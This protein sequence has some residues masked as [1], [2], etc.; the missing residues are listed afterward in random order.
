VGGHPFA[1]AV[2]M[3]LGALVP[4][5]AEPL[6][7]AAVDASAFPTV[8]VDIVAP[9][10]FSAE[11]V[12][13]A[14]V[15]V[16]GSAVESVTPVDPRDVVVGLVIDDRPGVSPAV[17]TALQG[18]AVELVRNTRRGIDV[19]LGTPSGLRTALTS[20]R[21]ANIARIAGITAGSPAVVQLPDVVTDTV[22]ELSSSESV[23][24]HA[25]VVLGDA[26]EATESQLAGL[27]E[28]VNESG[29][30]LYV[31]APASGDAGALGRIAQRSGGEVSTSPEALAAVDAVT[32]MISNR[33]RVVATV[34]GG[35]QHRIRLTVGG[36]RFNAAFD[37]AAA[38][39]A[40]GPSS[41][42]SGPSAPA[43]TAPTGS[44]VQRGSTPETIAEDAGSPAPL[45]VAQPAPLDVA[46]P[47]PLDVA[48]PAMDGG[49]PG[50]AI[51][52]GALVLAVVV[53][54]GVGVVIVVRRRTGGDDEE[55]LVAKKPADVPAA[56]K[57]VPMT[58]PAPTPPRP[59]AAPSR[60]KGAGPPTRPTGAP[61]R[62]KAAP[63][64]TRPTAAAP[65][66]TKA[67]PPARPKAALPPAR[68][69]PGPASPPP[70]RRAALVTP[71]ARRPPRRAKPPG[72]PPIADTSGWIVA[73]NLRVSPALGEVWCGEREIAL[74]PSEL[75][76]LEL[77]V[78][79]G[80]RGVTREAIVAAGELDD[81]AGP[82]AVDAIVTQVRR[83]T[84]IR[85]RGHA[86]RKE[87]VVTY[88]LE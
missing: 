65:S 25:V 36:Q 32:A 41:G 19:S 21:D 69:K 39:A 3:L 34:A 1:A 14:M 12:T 23:D 46:Q 16:D 49:L 37:V 62:S 43:S 28:A 54:V 78:T 86:V 75:R 52:L 67:A 35:G 50:R 2:S 61:S 76:V 64:P 73:G 6:D 4:P 45:D 18:A 27:A 51:V 66:R 87:R 20:D 71:L 8:V 53:L 9:V 47:A 79:S 7:I 77:L 48:Q 68:P 83:K 26:V 42:P 31:V 72:P 58:R 29:T 44:R 74:S 56:A 57:P 38:A 40:E 22:A 24:R 5:G 82:D 11:P 70:R 80:D 59:R 85:G 33:Y 10:R 55:L 81:S 60:S 63:P 15:V 17:V 30:V 84:G 13:A 88:F